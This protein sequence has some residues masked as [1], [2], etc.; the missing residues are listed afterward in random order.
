[1]SL[2]AKAVQLS[3][4][5]KQVEIDLFG[6]LEQIRD[7]KIYLEHGCDSLFEYVVKLL[8]LPPSTAYAFQ[9]A[10]RKI[11][12]VPE[13]KELV[14]TGAL[15]LC[16]IKRIAPVINAANSQEWIELARTSTLREIDRQVAAAN[17][18]VV[19]EKITPKSESRSEL[20]IGISL[21]FEEKLKRVQDLVSNQRRQS[22]S[23]E[24]AIEAA[25]DA[26]LEKFSARRKSAST[27][28]PTKIT[29][30]PKSSNVLVSSAA[31]EAPAKKPALTK[32]G[33]STPSDDT[34]TSPTV[35]QPNR[36]LTP[37]TKRFVLVRDGFR[38]TFT[39][40]NG[41]RCSNT[42][43]LDIHHIKPRATGGTHDPQN[44]ATL[45]SGHHLQ[46]HSVE[47]GST[48]RPIE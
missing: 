5:Y 13:L 1:M 43:F 12:E 7:R 16:K 42:R 26:F 8:G 22:V 47:E 14:E 30:G 35:T 19:T 11:K 29:I 38:C 4:V 9:I 39:H 25:L 15:S 32:Q 21:S 46:H 41:R 6:I 3:K 24:V 10:L 37:K 20:K 28:G 40:A 23:R 45:C 17:P 18:Q 33:N 44:L 2:H 48:A 36:T 34:S 31:A 27:K